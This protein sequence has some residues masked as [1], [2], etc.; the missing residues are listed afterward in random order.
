METLPKIP[1]NIVMYNEVPP[2]PS[3][4]FVYECKY[5]IFF[6][7]N[8]NTPDKSACVPVDGDIKPTSWCL[9]WF[10]KNPLELR[11]LQQTPK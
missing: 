4:L 2:P 9:L 7:P 5:C 3:P 6:K 8:A 10:A 11:F 1:K